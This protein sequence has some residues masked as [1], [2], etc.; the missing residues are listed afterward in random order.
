MNLI[1]YL[2]DYFFNNFVCEQIINI[3]ENRQQLA[4]RLDPKPE[5]EYL[6]ARKN[7]GLGS[8]PRPKP[9]TQRDQ[10]S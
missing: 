5:R 3:Q 7:L 4:I 9:K 8:G 6:W 2:I 1:L 10:D